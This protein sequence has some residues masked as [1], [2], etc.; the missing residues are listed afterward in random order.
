MP[1]GRTRVRLP[2]VGMPDLAA[3]GAK[4]LASPAM[5]QITP[6]MRSGGGRRTGRFP[7]G[8]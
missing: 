8:H 7:S 3:L 2:G 4:L 5:I 6:Q 1:A